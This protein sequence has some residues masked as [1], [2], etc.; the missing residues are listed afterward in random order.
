[1]HF[2]IGT[3]CEG[4]RPYHCARPSFYDGMHYDQLHHSRRRQP[5]VRDDLHADRRCHERHIGS[6]F[7]F[8]VRYGGKGSGDR[9]RYQ[10]DPVLFAEC[11]LPAEAEKHRIEKELSVSALGIRA[12]FGA[13]HQQLYYTAVRRAC[14]GPAEQSAKDLWSHERLRI[15]NPDHC[16]G[17]RCK[18]QRDSEQRRPWVGNRLSTDH[19]IQFWRAKLWQGQKNT[20][21]GDRSQLGRQYRHIYTFSN[22]A[23]WDHF[24]VWRQRRSALSGIRANGFSDIYALCHREQHSNAYRYFFAGDRA[25]REKFAA[26][27]VE[28]SHFPSPG[29]A[30]AGTLLWDRGHIGCKAGI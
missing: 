20:K 15:G 19:R 14:Y 28:T 27:P 24:A 1:M 3:L 21:D 22:S 4:L 7:Y 5:Q 2:G 16:A 12:G 17:D 18:D 11:R 8:C 26:L 23:G 9:H 13:G 25:K 10:P 30:V 29:D 6:H